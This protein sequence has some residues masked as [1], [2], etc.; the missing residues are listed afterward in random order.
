M[1]NEL[2]GMACNRSD[3]ALKPASEKPEKLPNRRPVQSP[4]AL[5]YKTVTVGLSG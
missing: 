4:I 5:A 2:S 1:S 3:G